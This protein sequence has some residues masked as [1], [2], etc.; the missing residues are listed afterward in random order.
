MSEWLKVYAW[1]VYVGENL[2]G[3]RI[4][5][6]PPLYAIAPIGKPAITIGV[7]MYY[8]YCLEN[9]EKNIYTLDQPKI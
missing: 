7:K 9:T 8:T 6:S 5:P 1:K 3:V 4:S 2:P